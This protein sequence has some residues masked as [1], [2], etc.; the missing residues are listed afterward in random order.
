M[1][2]ERSM[3]NLIGAIPLA[4]MYAKEMREIEDLF[5]AGKGTPSL[6]ATFHALAAKRDKVLR[7]NPGTAEFAIMVGETARRA[8]ACA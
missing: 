8:R 5:A 3:S 4:T 6:E 7:E 2:K 1:M